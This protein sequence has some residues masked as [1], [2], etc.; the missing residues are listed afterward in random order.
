MTMKKK[1]N[2]K[3][4]RNKWYIYTVIVIINRRAYPICSRWIWLALCADLFTWPRL[5]NYLRSLQCQKSSK[6]VQILFVLHTQFQCGHYN[7]LI[8]IPLEKAQASKRKHWI[9]LNW[10]QFWMCEGIS[11]YLWN[12]I[13][14]SFLTLARVNH[15]IHDTRWQTISLC[16]STPT[17]AARGPP[18]ADAFLASGHFAIGQL[19]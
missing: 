6:L 15:G 14:K 13:I 18:L 7:T 10:M 9:P 3:I 5:Y 1:T 11:F 12:Y 8:K 4:L 2:K 16:G 17:L 19:K